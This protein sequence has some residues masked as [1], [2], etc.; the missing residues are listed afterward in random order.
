MKDQV[1]AMSE[2][3]VKAVYTDEVDNDTEVETGI[4][5]GKYRLVFIS[6]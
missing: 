1:G 2:Q 3:N 5:T 6:P 4:L